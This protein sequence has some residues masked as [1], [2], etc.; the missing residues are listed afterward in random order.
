MYGKVLRGMLV[1]DTLDAQFLFD[2]VGKTPE[3]V[4]PTVTAGSRLMQ[5][6]TTRQS[7]PSKNSTKRPESSMLRNSTKPR[8]IS[9]NQG[10]HKII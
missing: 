1:I 10:K 8:I 6:Q 2:V 9:P 4:P 7:V 3:Y 5:L